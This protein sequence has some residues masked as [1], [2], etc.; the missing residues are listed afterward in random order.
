VGEGKY[1]V[2]FSTDDIDFGGMDR[3]SKGYVY[4]TK[5]E[6]GHGLGFEIYI[7]CRTAIV[8]KRL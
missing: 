7:P 4:H 3:T 1:R 5:F 2:I 8:F 6:E